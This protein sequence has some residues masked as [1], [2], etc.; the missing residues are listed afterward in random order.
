MTAHAFFTLPYP[1]DDRPMIDATAA[2]LN[3]VPVT[4]ELVEQAYQIFTHAPPHQKLDALLAFARSKQL[5]SENIAAHAL[6]VRA[7]QLA[8]IRADGFD[9]EVELP[10]LYEA[11]TNGRITA[12]D[13][14]STEIFVEPPRSDEP[15]LPLQ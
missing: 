6:L 3:T 14:G 13:L 15:E 11:I 7:Y 1:D 8:D 10:E 9:V 5:A 12:E 2:L 4:A